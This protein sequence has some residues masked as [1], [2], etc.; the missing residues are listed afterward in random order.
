MIILEML[1]RAQ[2]LRDEGNR[3]LASALADSPRRL[4]WR[5]ARFI[6]EALRHVP[7][8]HPFPER[9]VVIGGRIGILQIFAV[10]PPVMIMA[11]TSCGTH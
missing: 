4:M 6:G 7:N 3:Q 1:G 8:E 9:T 5:L 11:L 10:E 2:M